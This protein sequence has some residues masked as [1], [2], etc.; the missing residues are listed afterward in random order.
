MN[1]HTIVE[2]IEDFAPLDLAENWDCS[3]WLVK[4]NKNEVNKVMLALTITDEI[5]NQANA[6]NCD[7]IISH[8]PLFYVP[9]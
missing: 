1:K 5:I 9:L 4:T 8:H 6:N 3:G 7:M 2:K